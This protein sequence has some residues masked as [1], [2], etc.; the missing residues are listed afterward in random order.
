MKITVIGTGYVGLVVG[1]CFSDMGNDVWCIDNNEKRIN[2]LK[3]GIIPIFEKDIEVL[4]KKNYEEGRLKFSTDLNDGFK[5]SLFVFIAVGTPPNEDGS[6]DLQHVLKV[7]EEIG[8]NIENYKIIINKST[9]P[10][11]TTKRVKDE[12]MKQL[13]KRGKNIEFDVVSNPEF[14][15]EGDAVN[16]FMRPDRV[17]IGSS[18]NKAINYLKE[19]YSVFFKQ[20]PRV[21]IM[22]E[23]S[24]EITKYASNAMLATKI[25]FMNDMAN[26]CEKTGADIEKVRLGIGA[27]CRIGYSF[28]YP[29][30][31]YGGSCFP[32]DVKAIIHTANTYDYDMKVLKAV[33]EVNKLQKNR[34]FEK[35]LDYYSAKNESLNGKCFAIWG[36]AFKPETDDMR[37]AASII[38]INKLIENGA[39]IHA[40]DPKAINEAKRIFN[41]YNDRIKYFE[42]NYDC[43]IDCDGLLLLTEWHIYRQPDFDKI[44]Y[45]LKSHL[46]FD[47]RN[48]YDVNEMK[49][50]KI[51][52]FCIGR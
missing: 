25:S 28:I 14:L 12:I 35:V 27:D 16:D 18:S 24:A 32:K 51:D 22:D 30:I 52:Y 44:K 36:L 40:T 17:I 42:N 4:V 13:V 15:K 2:D 9:V 26:L 34:L 11:G 45:N 46:I 38:T 29:G 20:H 41:N 3:K 43:L 8:K 21:I 50:L 31:G 7:A 6:A 1:T 48:Q 47:G 10:V 39:L 49:K 33:E 5:E 37:E 19:L 23:Q